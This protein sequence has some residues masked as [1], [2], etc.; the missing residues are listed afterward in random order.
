[1]MS[2]R[3]EAKKIGQNN[4]TEPHK[5]CVLPWTTGRLPSADL[6][7]FGPAWERGSSATGMSGGVEKQPG[8]SLPMSPQLEPP[9]QLPHEWSGKLW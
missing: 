1:M 3:T 4:A 2:K 6:S 5:K 8:S 7:K 9:G